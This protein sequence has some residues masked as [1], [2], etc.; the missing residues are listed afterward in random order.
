MVGAYGGGWMDEKEKENEIP[1][2]WRYDGKSEWSSH[3]ARQYG[4]R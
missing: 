2:R 4:G 3:I 1:R